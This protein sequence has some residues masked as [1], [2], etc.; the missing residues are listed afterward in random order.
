MISPSF[1]PL[2]WVSA[3]IDPGGNVSACC[4]STHDPLGN[5]KDDSLRAIYHNEKFQKLRQDMLD[6]K[7]NEHCNR[8]KRDEDRGLKSLRTGWLQNW[9]HYE[10][11][12]GVLE[13]ENL[14]PERLAYVNIVFSNLCNLKCQMCGPHYS[15]SWLADWKKLHG[16]TGGFGFHET[17][18]D[19]VNKSFD[20]FEHVLN[21]EIKGGEPFMDANLRPFLNE[22]VS[23]G[24]TDKTIFIITNGTV[25][26]DE[27]LALLRPFREVKIMVSIDSVGPA[28][29]YMRGGQYT[30]EH[31]E[32]QLDRIIKGLPENLALGTNGVYQILNCFSFSHLI[33][34]WMNFCQSRGLQYGS[35]PKTFRAKASTLSWPAHYMVSHMP[36]ELKAL[37]H[38]DLERAFQ[39]ASEDYTANLRNMQAA[40]NLPRDVKH[41]QDFL[42]RTKALDAIRGQSVQEVV[43][44]LRPYFG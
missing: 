24:W 1:C 8:C 34:W 27:A 14:T 3:H 22:L 19:D 13:P 12:G 17:T 7:W 21:F 32:S 43:P 40:L 18:F 28:Y 5:L 15:T 23:R 11:R 10:A 44:E 9:P 36:D 39:F 20:M 42:S 26:D 35:G 6:G 29:S 4:R 31:L 41:W 2:P 30:M 37:A 38:T 33:E 25:V 16:N